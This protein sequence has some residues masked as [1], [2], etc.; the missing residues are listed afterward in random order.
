[1]AA[2]N[3]SPEEASGFLGVSYRS[4]YRWLNGEFRPSRLSRRAVR[5]GIRRMEKLKRD[6]SEAD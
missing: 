6:R 5:N 3:L 4:I 2:L 1:M